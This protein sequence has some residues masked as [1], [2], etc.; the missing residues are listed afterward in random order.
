MIYHAPV[1]TEK[2]KEHS[3]HEESLTGGKGHIEQP[4]L[5]GCFYFCLVIKKQNPH[6]VCLCGFISLAWQTRILIDH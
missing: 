3:I 4:A 6:K 2:A 5:A 1:P